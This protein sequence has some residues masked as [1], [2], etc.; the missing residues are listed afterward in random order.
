M[1]PRILCVSDDAKAPYGTKEDDMRRDLVFRMLRHASRQGTEVI[2]MMCNTACLEDLICIKQEIEKEAADERRAFVVHVIDLIETTSQAIVERGGLRPVLLSTEATEKK[3][4]Y[5]E[6]ILAFSQGRAEQPQVLVI[7]AGDK[8]NPELKD[9]DWPTLVN[10]GYHRL[11][12]NPAIMALLRR[13]VRRYVERIPLDSTSV[14][15]CCTHFPALKELVEELLADRLREAGYMHKI[16]V[17]DP[18]T[19]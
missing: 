19:D 7:A 8:N 12:D 5:P 11:K 13:E 10:K 17:F 6:K 2:V 9:M 14:W 15:L 4:R 1:D 18:V 16:P 3:G